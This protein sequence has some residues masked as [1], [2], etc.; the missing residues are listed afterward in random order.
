METSEPLVGSLARGHWRWCTAAAE[1][2][3]EQEKRCR[4]SSALHPSIVTSVRVL[5]E[6]Q[7]GKA[8]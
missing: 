2:A 8:G 4:S 5:V 7:L 3:G 6:L 1:N